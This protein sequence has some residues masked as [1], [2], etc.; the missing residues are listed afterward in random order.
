MGKKWKT[1]ETIK[2]LL[3]IIMRTLTVSVVHWNR[4]NSS[5]VLNLSILKGY[6]ALY[7]N[8]LPP[9]QAGSKSHTISTDRAVI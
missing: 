9:E 6:H 1:F 7:G 4:Y 5:Y 2:V 8:S 3:T